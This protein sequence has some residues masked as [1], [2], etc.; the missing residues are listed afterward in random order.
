MSVNKN[1]NEGYEDP[2]ID[3]S[4]MTRSKVKGA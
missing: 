2:A 3:G 4:A 1:R